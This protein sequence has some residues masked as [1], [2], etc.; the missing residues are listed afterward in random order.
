MSAGGLGRVAGGSACDAAQGRLAGSG[1]EAGFG[2]VKACN[3][4]LDVCAWPRCCTWSWRPGA[5]QIG[6]ANG[7]R[8]AGGYMTCQVGS[9]AS[10]AKAG[11]GIVSRWLG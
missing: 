9:E 10:E 5:F 4:A 1:A 11:I 3:D 2:S 8:A 7:E 6:G